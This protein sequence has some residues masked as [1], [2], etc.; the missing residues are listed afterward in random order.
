MGRMNLERAK[1]EK[2]DEFYTPYDAVEKELSHY[3]FKG[4]TVLCPCSDLFRNFHKYFAENFR[5]LG[6]KKLIVLGDNTLL[7]VDDEYT[8]VTPLVSSKY[9]DNHKYFM[10]ADIIVTNPPFSL[11][12]QFF[13]YLE[14][15]GKQYLL[16]CTYNALCYRDVIPAL[17]AKRARV[18]YGFG[19]MN[20]TLP[21]GQVKQMRNIAWITTLLVTKGHFE[22][23]AKGIEYPCFDGT[24][25]ICVDR[26]KDIP[27]DYGGVMGVPITFFQFLNDEWELLG[28]IAANKETYCCNK[29]DGK[30]R[31]TR[32]AVRR[33]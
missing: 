9:E 10:E 20:F 7:E 26:V 14:S 19:A 1:K 5:E 32:L 29:V 17:V 11:F 8:T 6:L 3:D 23:T 13:T 31:F 18:G 12:R 24:D 16:L 22:A 27:K 15:L 33:K 2:N 4:M 28:K 25:V 21:D 30:E